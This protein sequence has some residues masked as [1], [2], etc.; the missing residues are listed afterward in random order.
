[1]KTYVIIG[2]NE[3]E[4]NIELKKNANSELEALSA[5]K[6]YFK[7]KPDVDLDTLEVYTLEEFLTEYAQNIMQAYF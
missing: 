7:D 4:Y 3:H 2:G 5:A 1:M 6:E